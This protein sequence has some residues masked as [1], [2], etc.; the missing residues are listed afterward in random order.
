MMAAL[1]D[2]AFQLGKKRPRSCVPAIMRPSAALPWS[3]SCSLK[4]CTTRAAARTRFPSGRGG[5]KA[6]P[7]PLGPR[8]FY[9]CLQTASALL[10]RNCNR[11]SGRLLFSSR[12]IA[13]VI[14]FMAPRVGIEPTTNGLTVRCSTAELPGN[15]RAPQKGADSPASESAESRKRAR[16]HP[17]RW[18]ASAA[19]LRALSRR[20]RRSGTAAAVAGLAAS[21]LI[22]WSMLSS[23]SARPVCIVALAQAL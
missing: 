20:W 22:P 7:Y 2:R 18:R 13:Q 12:V 23:P 15:W 11:R 16:A 21:R 19:S 14:V 6:R 4:P 10:Q 8:R 5:R 9:R 17:H 1:H 3:A